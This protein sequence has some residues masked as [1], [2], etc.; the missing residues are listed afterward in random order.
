MDADTR[1]VEECLR[2][3]DNALEQDG[4]EKRQPDEKIAIFIPK[5][6]IETW[7]YYLQGNSVNEEQAY[8]KLTQESDCKTCVDALIEQCPQGLDTDAPSSLQIACREIPKIF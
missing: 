6:N 1:T 5:R 2:Q 3:L 7:I 4:Q 8:P